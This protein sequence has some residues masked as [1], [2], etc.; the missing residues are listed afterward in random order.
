MWSSPTE[1]SAVTREGITLVASSRP[2]RPASTTAASHPGRG[3]GDE[4]GRDRGLELGDRLAL[5]EARGSTTAAASAVRSTAAANAA[6]SISAPPI[7]TRS[8]QRR[9]AARGRQPALTPC[10]SSSAAVIRATDD[11]PLVPTTWSEREAVLG[12]AQ[13]VVRRCIRSS[14]KRQPTGSSEAR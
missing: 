10:A 12:L 4:R 9:R 5:L 1:V 7:R 11:L 13:R 2:P 3:E 6:G 8:L 14:P